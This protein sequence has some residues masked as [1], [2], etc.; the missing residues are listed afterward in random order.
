MICL[1]LQVFC[2]GADE[3]QAANSRAVEQQFSEEQLNFF[4]SRIRPVLIKH[5]YECHAAESDQ[6][7][8]GL[9]LDSRA[10]LLQG[11]D[12]GPA[13]IPGDPENSQL[14][15]ALRHETYE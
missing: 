8:G 7:R 15:L 9:L 13:V 14:L 1:C 5:C 6:I 12:S 11:G 3:P 10:A 4:E 2:Y